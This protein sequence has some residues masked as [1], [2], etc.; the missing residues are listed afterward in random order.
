MRKPA[1]HSYLFERS[2][3]R[4]YSALLHALFLFFSVVGLPEFLRSK[5]VEEPVAI[6]VELLPIS[7][8]SNVKPSEPPPEPEQKPQEKPPEQKKPAPPVKTAEAEPPPP[9]PDAAALPDKPL[10]KEKKPE[11]PKEKKEEK[12]A[13]KKKEKPKEDPLAA[14]LK[15]VKK[16]AQA[17]QKEKK[18]EAKSEASESENKS[19]SSQYDPTKQMSLSEKD[20]I[21]SQVQKC[22]NVPAG[23]KN[24]QEL[25]VFIEAEYAVDGTLIKAKIGNDTMAKAN[26]D[27]FVRAAAES[28]LRA[29]QRC[30]PLQGLQ[31]DKFAGWQYMRHRFDPKDMLN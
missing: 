6:T 28:A 14:I 25:E 16:T 9:P 10:E 2:K 15:S 18:S 30:Q 11:P 23:A 24:A 20:A 3:G 19:M 17:E 29:V 12:V 13:D 27:P 26:G 1:P 22:W 31:Q 7:S 5:P 4:L 21:A 8:V